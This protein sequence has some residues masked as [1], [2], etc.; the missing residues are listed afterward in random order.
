MMFL[1]GML[2][3]AEYKY[4]AV[5]TLGTAL[6][7]QGGGVTEELLTLAE[8]L[9]VDVVLLQHY[10]K[11]VLSACEMNIER[12][13]AVM[14]LR[15]TKADQGPSH[16][17]TGRTATSFAPSLLRS[18]NLF[19]QCDRRVSVVLYVVVTIILSN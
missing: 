8:L 16:L 17:F 7:S 2:K 5:H 4:F 18:T 15:V 6:L 9:Q 12:C 11:A 3:S 19:M 10:L 1:E 14:R 13:A